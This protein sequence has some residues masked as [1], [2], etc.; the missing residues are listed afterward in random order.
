MKQKIPT[1]ILLGVV[2]LIIWSLVSL[3]LETKKQLR[4]TQRLL[5]S[6]GS[7]EELERTIG[8]STHEYSANEIPGYMKLVDGFQMREDSIVRQ[9]NKEGLPYWWVLVQF[10]KEDSEIV[11][12]LAAER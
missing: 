6:G 3:H 11:W 7:L 4:M 12:Y 2:G 8:R 1:A 10:T 5:K 9:Y